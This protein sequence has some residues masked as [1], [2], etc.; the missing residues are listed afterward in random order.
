MIDHT[1]LHAF[2]DDWIDLVVAVEALAD[3]HPGL[4][5]DELIARLDADGEAAIADTR[6]RCRLKE[7]F[8]R[9]QSL[10]GLMHLNDSGPAATVEIPG[11]EVSEV[12]GYG[13]IGVVYRAR[14]LSLGRDVAIKLMLG[15]R[16]ASQRMRERFRREAEMAARLHHPNVA[17]VYDHGYVDGVP[18]LV[19][20]L[21]AGGTLDAWIQRRACPVDEAAQMLETLANTV[22]YAHQN[23]IIHRD[24]KPA[25]VLLT[26]DGQPKIVDFGLAKA[27]DLGHDLTQAH[28]TPG[29]PSYMAPEQASGD[30][31]QVG[32]AADVYALGAILYEMLTGRCVFDGQSGADTLRRVLDEEP[33]S[34]ARYRPDVPADLAA[35]CLK[36][37]E[38][39]PAARYASCGEFSADLRRFLNGEPTVARPVSTARRIVK[40][41]RRRPAL[42]ALVGVSLLA[43]VTIVG[44]SA[45]YSRRLL[46]ALDA[47]EQSRVAADAARL[48]SE[49]SRNAAQ[50]Q[51]DAN[52]Q[53]AYA[54]RMRE[55]FQFL[56][57]GDVK[58]VASLLAQ[59]DDGT[60]YARLRGFEWQYL[61]RALHN[62]RLM[63][64][65]HA[66]EVYGVAF[67]PD[68][69]TLVSGGQDGTIRLWDPGT[70]EPLRVIRAH[71]SCANDLHFSRDG[72]LMASASCDRTVKLWDTA[73]WSERL[74][75]SGH[76]DDVLCVRISPDGN[77][78]ASG[79]S[80]GLI[81][82]WA[83][84]DGEPLKT[85][86][87]AEERTAVNVIEWFPDGGRLVTPTSGLH[88]WDTQSW[89]LKRSED[90]ADFSLSFSKDGR[91]LTSIVG[92]GVLFRDATSL[93]VLDGFGVAAIGRV[94]K[95]AYLNDDRRLVSCGDDRMVH[96]TDLAAR[97]KRRPFANP[98]DNEPLSTEVR[99][100]LGHT[101]RVQGVAIAPD[102]NTLATASF[103]GAVGL[104]ELNVKRRVRAGD[105]D[106]CYKIVGTCATGGA[107]QGLEPAGDPGRGR[108]TRNLGRH[109][110]ETSRQPKAD[111]RRGPKGYPVARPGT[112]WH[113]GRR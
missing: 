63:L 4:G 103:D 19:E 78:V 81:H 21:V 23:G 37:L 96:I 36:C 47:S 82:V 20:E 35:I 48:E 92:R 32:P 3:C 69:R 17:Q 79:D 45:E 5:F 90:S 88:L 107:I 7:H 11:F 97:E 60:P 85:L 42:A 73:T 12:L 84:A 65:G 102:G 61:T 10:K 29:T 80:S 74:V 6:K 14:Q 93:E 41:S 59:Y 95:L 33:A 22:R 53:F 101:A 67:S 91:Q 24:L 9:L 100:L 50:R 40:W 46:A 51:R 62:E 26:D 104:W 16:F 71:G 112:V 55:A 34:P 2:D 105:H 38:K 76:G 75:F 83:S 27:L 56:S 25:N 68:G 72:R 87:T 13:G 8:D 31:A 15:G 54:A 52:E 94:Y 66:G 28:E 98:R 99:T 1:A 44:G 109:R 30:G 110:V 58:Q 70:G 43:A 111:P 106:R 89:A 57:L 18:Y 86:R 113:W 64:R 77:R 49:A 108:S 39:Q